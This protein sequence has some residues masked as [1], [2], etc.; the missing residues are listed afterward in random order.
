M[1]NIFFIGMREIWV[2]VRYS[3]IILIYEV[4]VYGKIRNIITNKVLKGYVDVN[5]YIQVMLK[6][7]NNKIK[8]FRIHTLVA[9]T[10]RFLD[11]SEITNTVNHKDCN[12][13]NNSVL[14]LEWVSNAY[15]I[16]HARVN[17]TIHSICNFLQ[18]NKSYDQIISFLSLKNTKSTRVALSRIKRRISFY[19]ISKDYIWINKNQKIIDTI[20]EFINKNNTYSEICHMLGLKINS[21]S[22][23][24]YRN[25]KNYGIGRVQRLEH[26]CS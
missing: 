10:Y 24:I 25:I 20:S 8:K 21:A 5:G 4:S 3:N 22:R 11:Y 19:H 23:D 15:N 26:Q 6:T 7:V 18:M 16:E 13:L 9:I 2:R 17:N 1:L 14:N 12:K